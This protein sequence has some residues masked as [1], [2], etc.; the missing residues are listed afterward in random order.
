MSNLFIANNKRHWRPSIGFIVNF[1]Q[2]SHI[3][4]NSSLLTLKKSSKKKKLPKSSLPQ[5]FIKNL[6]CNFLLITIDMQQLYM[7]GI[8]IALLFH[9]L[10]SSRPLQ[11]ASNEKRKL[12]LKTK[13]VEAAT[14]GVLCERV[15]LEISQNSLENNFIKKRLWDRCFPVDFVKFVRTPFLQNTSGQLLLNM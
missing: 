8:C 13:Y 7:S 14:R 15:F 4:L 1:E 6:I 12:F 5:H 10:L 3:A 2:I 11:T 9:F